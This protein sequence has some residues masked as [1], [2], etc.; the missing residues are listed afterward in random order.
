MGGEGECGRGIAFRISEKFW[1]RKYHNHRHNYTVYSAYTFPCGKK[2][3]EAEAAE[4]P[5]KVSIF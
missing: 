5:E 3:S 4:A 1:G 2:A